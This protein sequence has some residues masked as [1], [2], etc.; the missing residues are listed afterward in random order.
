MIVMIPMESLE[1]LTRA[2]IRQQVIDLIGE[3]AWQYTYYNTNME[4]LIRECRN[5]Y[6]L[7]EKIQDLVIAHL[8]GSDPSKAFGND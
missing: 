3:A 1:G 7:A 6:E 8:S 4:M 2:E 5:V